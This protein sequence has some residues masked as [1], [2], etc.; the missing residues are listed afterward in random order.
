M[1]TKFGRT[2]L[3]GVQIIGRE[4]LLL[5]KFMIINL[6]LMLNLS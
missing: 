4:I 1:D 6:L 5:P 2:F 3:T